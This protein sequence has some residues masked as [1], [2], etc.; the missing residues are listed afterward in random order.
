[1]LCLCMDFPWA[2]TVLAQSMSGVARTCCKTHSG[3][4]TGECGQ[5]MACAICVALR[6]P[7]EV[8]CSF[9]G[10]SGTSG[11]GGGGRMFS[12]DKIGLKI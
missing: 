7:Q 5:G 10:N 3:G 8:L 12:S 6:R 9:P 1:M 4:Q 2:Q 11:G